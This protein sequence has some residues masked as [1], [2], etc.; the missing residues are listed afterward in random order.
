MALLIPALVPTAATRLRTEMMQ[1]QRAPSSA[2][3]GLGSAA[4]DTCS[5]T[6]TANRAMSSCS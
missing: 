2:E 5:T 1:N 3:A 6:Q 4:V